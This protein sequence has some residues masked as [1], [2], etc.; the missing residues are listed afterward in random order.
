MHLEHHQ[1]EFKYE[2]LRIKDRAAQSQLM[3]SLAEQ[4]QH[5]AVWVVKG[6]EENK[7]VLIDGYRRVWALQHSGRDQVQALE[8]QVGEAEALVQSYR[9]NASRRHTALEEGWLLQ[10]LV[11]DHGLSEVELSRKLQRSKS[12]INR[13][14]ALVLV[15]PETVQRAVREGRV[16]AQGAMKYLVPL[17][18]ANRSHCELL[19]S[20][21]GASRVSVRELERIYMAWRLGD[22]ERRRRI[23]TQPLLFLKATEEPTE[24]KVTDTQKLLRL[25][26][27]ITDRCFRARRLL[28]EGEI[29]RRYRRLDSAWAQ[30]EQAFIG[31]KEQI[32]EGVDA[33]SGHT[34]GDSTFKESRTRNE[35]HCTSGGGEP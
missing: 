32:Q 23:V 16:P 25:L 21:L 15:L 1:L 31:L 7:W 12:W 2:S 19:V 30:A 22:S 3:S 29:R 14:M 20:N 33:G 17:S 28:H 11:Q 8:L 9:L 35:G 13:R 26:E 6:G 5:I 34:H 24:D 27:Q 18:R 4:G 10:L